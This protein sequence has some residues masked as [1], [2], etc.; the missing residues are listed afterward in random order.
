MLSTG[1]LPTESVSLHR[2]KAQFMVRLGSSMCEVE[3]VCRRE[4]ARVNGIV[5]E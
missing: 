1:D 5:K 2:A 4:G 3:R